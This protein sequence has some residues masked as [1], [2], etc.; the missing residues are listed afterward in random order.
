MISNIHVEN[1]LTNEGG[2]TIYTF[3]NLD[4]KEVLKGTLNFNRI[5]IRKIGGSKD[6]MTLEIPSSPEFTE[7]EETVLFLGPEKEDHSFEVTG[8][9]L[10]KY[11]LQDQN[12]Q[13]VLTGGIFN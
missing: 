3:A 2:K 9:E 12:G 4:V 5:L 11:G 1:G 7:G 13:V 6:G 10:G 8:L